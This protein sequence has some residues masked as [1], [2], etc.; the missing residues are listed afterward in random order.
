MCV[1]GRVGVYNEP[2]EKQNHHFFQVI[3]PFTFVSPMPNIGL[4][5]YAWFRVGTQQYL[6]SV[7]MDHRQ[8]RWTL[9]RHANYK[10]LEHS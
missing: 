7:Q 1:C 6:I 8:H 10:I 2:T 5:L 3:S 4:I 9:I